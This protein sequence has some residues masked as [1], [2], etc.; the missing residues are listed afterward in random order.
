MEPSADTSSPRKLALHACCGP[1]LIEPFD[2]FD[3]PDVDVTV[4]FC[5]ANIQPAEEYETRKATLLQYAQRIGMTVVELPY[6]PDAWREA[7][8]EAETREQ[9][10]EACYLH[11][12][13]SVAKWAADNGCDS[14]ATTLTISPYQDSDAIARIGADCAKHYGI[15]YVHEDF[16]AQ[17]AEATRRSRDEG[18]Y[19]QNY[20]GCLPS[21]AE[22]QADRERRKA[23]RQARRKA[24]HD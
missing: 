20:C 1:C 15:N 8:D 14:F 12:L 7:T 6:D 24:Q 5:N 10:C 11:R 4:V 23:E 13:G 9:R 22:A 3:Q 18:M 2:A 17:Y 21:R 19:R 16:T